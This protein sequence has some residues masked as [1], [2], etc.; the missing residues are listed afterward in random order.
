MYQLKGFI[1]LKKMQKKKFSMPLHQ[2]DI[3][4]FKSAL[5]LL[6]YG[7]LEPMRFFIGMH[8]VALIPP[9][10]VPQVTSSSSTTIVYFGN[11]FPSPLLQPSQFCIPVRKISFSSPCKQLCED[12]MIKDFPKWNGIFTKFRKSD[13]SLKR[14]LESN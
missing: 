10:L 12:A 14:E 8:S 6:P 2:M 3:D 7:P 4:G 9:E 5:F 11:Y 1:L 13:K